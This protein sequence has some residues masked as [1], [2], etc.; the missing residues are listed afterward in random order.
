MGSIGPGVNSV[1]LVGRLA[2][3][4]VLRRVP[5]TGRV[6][7]RRLAVGA[8][9]GS[10]VGALWCQAFTGV[11][12]VGAE[13]V[14]SRIGWDRARAREPRKVGKRSTRRL[15]SWQLR[16]TSSRSGPRLSGQQR[17]GPGPQGAKRERCLWRD[18]SRGPQRSCARFYSRGQAPE[19][20]TL[21]GRQGL[22]NR[23][24][25]PASTQKTQTRTRWRNPW[26]RM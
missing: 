21:T 9:A 17:K 12:R 13:V 8:P 24:G 18:G 2:T 1:K 4:L 26:A 10:T 6:C 22:P 5:D 15:R 19:A 25:A 20:R 16:A 7:D 14:A 3:E 23:R 11:V